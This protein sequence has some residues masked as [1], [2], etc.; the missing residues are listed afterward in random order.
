MK[1]VQNK[2][3][4]TG[5]N[6]GI[7]LALAKKFISLGNEVIIVGRNEEDLKAV[8][9]DF[10]KIHIFACD[11]SRQE[12][13][14]NLLLFIEREHQD[15]NILVNNAGIQYNYHF[16]EE[17]QLLNKIEYES[18]VN[19]MAPIKL[20]ALLLPLLEANEDSAIINVSSSLAM[21][22]KANAPVYCATKAGLHVFSKALRMQL[23]KT[24]VFEIIPSLVDTAMTEGRG[25]DKISPEELVEE[26]IKSFS[27]D[28]YEVNI[29]KV[30]LLRLLQRI[31]PR[32]ASK[33]VNK[34]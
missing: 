1:V 14:D 10:P 33:I 15:L 7:G 13:I 24:K 18:R 26:F 34:K 8:K 12:D 3:L 21:V 30:K 25:R 19:F 22:P 11:L 2:I 4:I 6:K 16:L 32:L 5:G 31:S 29:G 17:K 20:T 23:E 9:A 27:R 28:D